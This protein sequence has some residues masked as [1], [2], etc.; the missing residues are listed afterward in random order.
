MSEIKELINDKDGLQTYDYIVNHVADCL[1]DMDFLTDNLL[2]V[3]STGK[4]LSS[5]ARFLAGVDKEKFGPWISR[6]IEGAISK[7]RER[8]YIGGLLEA[9][10]GSDYMEKA[11][12]LSKEDDNFRRIFKRIYP[13]TQNS[14]SI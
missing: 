14:S 12:V 10:W 5:S 11:D 1:S 3:D 7:D 9:I 6:L 13:A 2:K 4:Y 8:R